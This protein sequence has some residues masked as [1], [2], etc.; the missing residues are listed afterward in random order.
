MSLPEVLLWRCLRR[1]RAEGY[2]FRRQHPLGPYVLDFFC[3]RAALC[4][5]VDGASHGF[6]DRPQRDNSRDGYLRSQRI[7]VIRCGASDVLND[8]DA[9]ATRILEAA[10]GLR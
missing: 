8:A 6:G 9:V 2:A 1:G 4:V 10:R 3:A 5:E 7:R